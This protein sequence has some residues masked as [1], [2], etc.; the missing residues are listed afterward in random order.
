MAAITARPKERPIPREPTPPA[1][2]LA[3]NHRARSG[4]DEQEGAYELGHAAP[5]ALLSEAGAGQERRASGRTSTGAVLSPATCAAKE[6]LRSAASRL[7]ACRCSLCSRS[8]S[9]LSL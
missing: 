4:K 5:Y 7:A 9:S 1:G 6:V 2:D 3:Y 8:R